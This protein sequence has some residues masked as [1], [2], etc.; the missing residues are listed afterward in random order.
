MHATKAALSPSSSILLSAIALAGMS[1]TAAAA[2]APPSPY[3]TPKQ[4][5]VA[6]EVPGPSHVPNPLGGCFGP[7]GDLEWTILEDVIDIT[8]FGVGIEGGAAGIIGDK[9]YV[10]H[11]YSA[12]DSLALRIYDI[13]TDTWSLGADDP[14]GDARS[15]GVGAAVGDSLYCIGGR[16][17][18]TV[19][20][21]VDIYD[22]LSDTWSE[23]A[24]M[25][26]ARAGTGAVVVDGKIHVLGGRD[27]A[28][29]G[30]GAALDAHEVYDPVADS[31]DSTLAPLPAPRA[32]VMAVAIGDKIYAF[33]GYDAGAQDDTYIYDIPT[34][35]WTTGTDMPTPRY[36]GVAGE[37]F[38]LPVVI[39][40]LAETG[41]NTDVV[42]VY[43]PAGD[44]WCSGPA[45]PN[46]S[47]ELSVAGVSG[48]EGIYMIG[49]GAFGANQVFHERLSITGGSLPPILDC[50]ADLLLDC[51][52]DQDDIDA[53]LASATAE[54]GCTGEELEVT[55]VLDDH[56]EGCGGT[57]VDTYTFSAV[58]SLG[59][60]VECTRTLTVQD[61]TPPEADSE[62]LLGCIWPPNHWYVCLDTADLFPDAFDACSPP[63]TV[64]VLGCES[65]QPDNDIGDG[66]TTDDCV[67]SVDG[68]TVCVRAERQGPVKEGR[69]YTLTF[70]LEDACGNSTGPIGGGTIHVPHDQREHPDCRHVPHVGIK[71]HEPLPF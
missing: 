70:A 1:L 69:T 62:A 54:D 53:W 65:D 63:V 6:D 42:E 12:G 31:W 8:G 34:D 13:P 60:T 45:K 46:P 40:G 43:Q 21:Q 11:G 29:P 71:K 61:V 5:V 66:N 2:E 15:E 59:Q 16:P 50:P 18:G 52:A 35:T 9:I 3:A 33:G 55:A 14:N 68:T 32:D 49:S 4:A 20:V 26:T 19:G 39:S 44:T 17:V 24:D 28:S 47:S 67:A 51:P 7:C 57:Y 64:D 10:G 56:A 37:L 23:G 25:P 58:D 30:S 22:S 36:S 41:G 48:P 27:G 38:G